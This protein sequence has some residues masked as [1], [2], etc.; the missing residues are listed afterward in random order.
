MLLYKTSRT[1]QLSSHS[2]TSHPL[3]LIFLYRVAPINQERDP[4]S[5]SDLYVFTKIYN[6]IMGVNI[7]RFSVSRSK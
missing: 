4:C 7:Y 3:K 5:F 2:L 1:L 6:A